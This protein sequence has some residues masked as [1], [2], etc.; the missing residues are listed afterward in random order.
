MFYVYAD[1]SYLNV[2]PKDSIDIR[3]NSKFW[4]IHCCISKLQ[5]AVNTDS[6]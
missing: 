1:N 4:K 6:L 3:K 5:S 2:D